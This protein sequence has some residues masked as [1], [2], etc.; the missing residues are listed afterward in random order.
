MGISSAE[1]HQIENEMLFRRMNEKVGDDLGALD[2]SY[3]DDKEIYLIRDDDVLINFKCEC[4]DENCTVRIPLKLSEYQEIH[5][6]RDTFIVMPDH[7]VDPIE[8]VV[9]SGPNY[10]VVIKHNSTADPAAG[11]ALHDTTIDNSPTDDE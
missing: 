4:S 7:Q 9:S 2:A 11:Q 6:N 8:E 3:I 10:N 5:E 1:R